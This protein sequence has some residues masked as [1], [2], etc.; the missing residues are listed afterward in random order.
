MKKDKDPDTARRA[1][2][3]VPSVVLKDT[4][5]DKATEQ[6]AISETKQ[7]TKASE[8]SVSE[9]NSDTST[10]NMTRYASDYFKRNKIPYC[11]TCGAQH[12]NTP[13]GEPVC[14][15]ARDDCPRLEGSKK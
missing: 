1:V 8:E 5:A 3:E 12:Q 10:V 6:E 13:Q 4:P 7:A 11:L 15:E 9:E 14:A 2:A